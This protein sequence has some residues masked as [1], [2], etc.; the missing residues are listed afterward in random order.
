MKT[1]RIKAVILYLPLMFTIS[2]CLIFNNLAD[3]TSTANYQKEI[4]FEQGKIAAILAN[5]LRDYYYFD[6]QVATNYIDNTLKENFGNNYV[7]IGQTRILLSQ[8]VTSKELQGFHFYDPHLLFAKSDELAIIK[9]ALGVRYLV[10]IQMEER[11]N[12]YEY[13]YGYI[14]TGYIVGK[15]GGYGRGF[16]V[17]S[18]IIDLEKQDVY[19]GRLSIDVDYTNRATDY[20]SDL[21]SQ[22]RKVRNILLEN[23]K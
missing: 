14:A 16:L 11:F 18:N 17:G 7:T 3:F 22:V 20:L 23:L 10:V 6:E 19:Y 5:D 1:F 12:K 4:K 21:K 2:N 15:E 13:D 8:K 9:K